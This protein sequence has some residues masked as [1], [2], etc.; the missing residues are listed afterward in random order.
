MKWLYYQLRTEFHLKYKHNSKQHSMWTPEDHVPAQIKVRIEN[1][2]S[3]YQD[4][5]PKPLLFAFLE[6]ISLL[7]HSARTGWVDRKVPKPESIGDHMYRMGI[8][9]FL[10]E[11]EKLNMQKCQQIAL[12]HDMA[13]A[14]VGDITPYDTSC[15]KEEKHRR[16][17]ASIEYIRDLVCKFNFKAGNLIYDLWHEYEYQTTDEAKFVKDIDKLEFLAQCS[18]YEREFPH[19]DL[20]DMHHAVSKIKTPEVK[21]WA[22]AMYVYNQAGN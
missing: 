3:K 16:E 14:L 13:E 7:K 6:I 11:N 8:M 19:I 12:C 2:A 4:K 20:S 18:E 15:D 21:E 22:E 5:G 10:C 1:L 9:G 17:Q